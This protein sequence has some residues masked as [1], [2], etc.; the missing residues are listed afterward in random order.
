MTAPLEQVKPYQRVWRF[1]LMRRL[2]GA[3][4]L[5]AV[6]VGAGFSGT[7][8]AKSFPATITLPGATSAEGIATGIGSSFFAGDLFKGDIYRGDL[9]S[10]S[11]SLFI[12]APDGRMALGLKVDVPH[13]LL[14][15]AGGFTGQGYVYDARTGADVAVLQLA[16]APGSIINDVIVAGGAAWFTDSAQPHLYRVPMG[17]DGS[18]GT[19]STLVISGPAAH[20][21][22][23]FNMNGIAATPNGRTLIV[24]HSGDGALYT[25]NPVTGA[26]AAIAGADVPF[27]DGILFEAGR[28]WAVQ[29]MGNQITELRLSSDLSSATVERIITSPQFEIP[30]TV[31]RDGSR[32]AVIN[33][34]F[35]TGFPPSATSFEVVIVDGR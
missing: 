34:K 30:T 22:G 31:A 18:I 25:V 17:A 13:G 9:R 26:S 2:I 20:L 24:A 28:L 14:V 35:D 15:V 6:L 33:A 8:T 32:L 10:G 3:V 5:A 1:S 12:D 11:A 29:N 19:P 7:A 23:P 21:S 4:S 27:V 16:P